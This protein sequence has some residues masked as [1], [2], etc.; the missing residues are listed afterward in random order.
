[1]A[2]LHRIR[3]LSR[4]LGF[5]WLSFKVHYFAIKKALFK[6]GIVSLNQFQ[7]IRNAAAANL[8]VPLSEGFIAFEDTTVVSALVPAAHGK[9]LELGPGP[10]NQIQR[11][12]ESQI[13]FIYALEPNSNYGDSLAFK[14][15]KH[16]LTH[17]YKLITCGLED[18]D[19]L[20]REGVAEGTMDTVLSIQ[21]LCA[22]DNPERA[23]KE[24]YKLLKPGGKLIFW[25]H[26]KSKDT[27]M[28]YLQGCRV[29]RD[30][31]ADILAAGEWENPDEIEDPNDPHNFLPRVWGVLVKKVS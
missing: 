20:R 23:A 4:P 24:A 14:V 21:V 10:G 26:V 30:I 27:I 31:K 13:E 5:I 12:N 17:K 2:L 3:A 18:S 1:M 22:V 7:K 9:V 15:E 16:G 11:F 29:D 6:D 8:F 28:G 25:E 19:V